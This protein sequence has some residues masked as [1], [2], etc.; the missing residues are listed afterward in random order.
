MLTFVQSPSCIWLFVTPWTATRQA[1]CCSPSPS[2]CP[3]SCSMHWWCPPAISSSDTHFSFCPQAFPAS[4]TFPMNHLFC[5]RWPKYWSFSFRISPSSEYSGLIFLKSE[6]FDLLA[7]QVTLR[8]LFQ[9]HCSK[10]SILWLSAFFTVQLSYPQVT[11]G[12]VIALTT[13]TS[14]SRTMSLLFNT[15]SRFVITFFSRS[16]Y[17]LIS[18]LQSLSTVILKPNKRKYFMTSTFSPSICMK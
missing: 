14:V 12:K 10:A 8:S 3:S 6:W 17:L 18:W 5:I 7:V 9:H 13:W 1:A 16:N 4:E 11:T 2:V 15:L